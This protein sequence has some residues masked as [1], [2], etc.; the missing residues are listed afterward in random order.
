MAGIEEEGGQTAR[1]VVA[2]L[3]ESPLTLA[4]VVFN[5]VFVVVVYLG[6]R[7]NRLSI[8]RIMTTMIAQEAKTAEMLYY[9]T[10]NRGPR[11]P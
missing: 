2:S 5:V 8:D 7:E 4:L 3:K 10:P 11:E 6:T 1:S 9:C